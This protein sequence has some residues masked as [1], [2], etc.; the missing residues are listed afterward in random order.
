MRELTKN[1]INDVNGG[2]SSTTVKAGVK[3][4]G[5]AL[6]RGIAIGSGIGV[7]I[8]VGMIAYDV[9]QVMD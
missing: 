6:L 3:L 8:G 1:E 7:F 2:I 9:Y 4:L 5:G